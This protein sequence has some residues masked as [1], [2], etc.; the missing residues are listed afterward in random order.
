MMADAARFMALSHEH[1]EM[2]TAAQRRVHHQQRAGEL[3]TA[4]ELPQ[5]AGMAKMASK[6]VAASRSTTALTN[7]DLHASLTS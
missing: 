4:R 2:A 1:I 7:H 5:D 3:A 6:E